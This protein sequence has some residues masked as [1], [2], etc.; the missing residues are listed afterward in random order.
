MIVEQRSQYKGLCGWAEHASTANSQRRPS[1]SPANPESPVRYQH[2]RCQVSVCFLIRVGTIF[3]LSRET[4]RFV[5]N[6]CQLLGLNSFFVHKANVGLMLG[7]YLMT[8]LWTGKHNSRGY[9]VVSFSPL[10]I[11][12]TVAEISTLLSELG[13]LG[14]T[15]CDTVF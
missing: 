12:C 4:F 14:R 11:R 15:I 9:S 8:D 2:M 5:G 10:A 7:L 1:D 6:L 13:K 3:D